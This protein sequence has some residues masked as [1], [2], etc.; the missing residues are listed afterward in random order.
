MPARRGGLWSH[1]GGRPGGDSVRALGRL[2][3]AQT[4]FEFQR[5]QKFFVLPVRINVCPKYTKT[6]LFL[7][8]LVY[9]VSPM[10]LWVFL[11]PN[12]HCSTSLCTLD[13]SSNAPHAV[14]AFLFCFL[15][16]WNRV[17]WPHSTTAADG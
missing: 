4:A 5:T 6:G 12:P 13:F 16:G 7:F 2:S 3:G 11:E 1:R 14:Y 17:E 15:V 9:F 8:V 10:R